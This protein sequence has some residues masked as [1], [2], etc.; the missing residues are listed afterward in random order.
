MPGHIL[1]AVWLLEIVPGLSDGRSGLRLALALQLQPRRGR[2]GRNAAATI[3][4]KIFE[5]LRVETC[6]AP[7]DLGQNRVK[8]QLNP[9]ETLALFPREIVHSLSPLGILFSG[10]SRSS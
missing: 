3:C 4:Q 9:K 8:M 2:R 10:H 5:R 6:R 7:V 1:T